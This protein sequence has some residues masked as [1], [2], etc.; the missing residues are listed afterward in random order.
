MNLRKLLVDNQSTKIKNKI[1]VKVI[2]LTKIP[3]IIFTRIELGREKYHK[4]DFEINLPKG[5]HLEITVLDPHS[6]ILAHGLSSGTLLPLT[7]QTSYEWVS[8][9]IKAH[10]Q[11]LNL[12]FYI[13]RIVQNSCVSIPVDTKFLTE[14]KAI[15]HKYLAD[16]AEGDNGA[17]S[18]LDD[19]KKN[20]PITSEDLWNILPDLPI[21]ERI[22]KP[23]KSMDAYA[24]AEFLLKN[25]GNMMIR[26]IVGHKQLRENL[27]HKEVWN[28]LLFTLPVS[29]HYRECYSSFLKKFH[30]KESNS[31]GESKSKKGD[32]PDGDGNDNGNGEGGS[33]P[34]HM[35]QELL[36]TERRE[37]TRKF[38]G[39]QETITNRQVHAA[40]LLDEIELCKEER[41]SR[42]AEVEILRERIMPDLEN[43]NYYR[44]IRE[45]AEV[46]ESLKK[47][48]MKDLMRQHKVKKVSEYL[49][50]I[51]DEDAPEKARDTIQNY[52]KGIVMAYNLLGGDLLKIEKELKKVRGIKERMENNHGDV[53]NIEDYDG[54]LKEIEDRTE[55][56]NAMTDSLME[57]NLA[58]ENTKSHRWTL[59]HSY[60]ENIIKSKL[61]DLYSSKEEDDAQKQ[62]Q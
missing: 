28:P 48:L 1:A 3:D 35:N 15:L 47:H 30:Y 37:L 36:S 27:C 49:L 21:W 56:V 42:I 25:R 20:G 61:A 60:L 18:V 53:N 45:K 34:P 50:K 22:L 55:L 11:R 9:E 19:Q 23:V 38:M 17:G 44:E 10:M 6:N 41:L 26:T 29:E 58:I 24:H 62:Q 59:F 32:S 5:S 8:V 51:K 33:N 14:T 39:L 13:N 57:T 54:I 40:E 52:N 16:Q 31:K 2:K 46:L 43:N 4:L 12:Y 7:F